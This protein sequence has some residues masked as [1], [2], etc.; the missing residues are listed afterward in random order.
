MLPQPRWYSTVT[1][2]SPSRVV[3]D[4]CTAKV[5]KHQMQAN[6]TCNDAKSDGSR[7]TSS[8]HRK[9]ETGKL[10]NSTSSSGDAVLLE[11]PRLSA[12]LRQLSHSI[13]STPSVT[14]CSWHCNAPEHEHEGLCKSS[15]D[16]GEQRHKVAH[17]RHDSKHK[18]RGRAPR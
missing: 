7:K 3:N 8:A 10:P 17:L 4:L 15:D 1:S 18:L 14:A 13:T 6:G 16:Q 12:R 5:V 11:D 2:K 9:S